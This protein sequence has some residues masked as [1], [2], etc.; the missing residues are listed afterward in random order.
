MLLQ[1]Y[2][3]WNKTYL[4]KADKCDVVKPSD[5]FSSLQI[6]LNSMVKR[7]TKTL[8]WMQRQTREWHPSSTGSQSSA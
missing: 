7:Q 2:R 6:T 5:A 1:E 4:K 8:T 3:S